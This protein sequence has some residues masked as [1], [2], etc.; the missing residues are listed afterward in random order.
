MK[1]EDNVKKR[2]YGKNVRVQIYLPPELYAK[3]KALAPEYEPRW[4]TVLFRQM[5]V[6]W[7]KARKK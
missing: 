1:K 5:A 3:I 4:E 2:M 7:L 6:E